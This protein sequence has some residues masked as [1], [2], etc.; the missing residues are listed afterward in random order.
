MPQ[1]DT[2]TL[3]VCTCHIAKNHGPHFFLNQ[4]RLRQQHQFAYLFVY[5]M[6]SRPAADATRAI[7]DPMAS[8]PSSLSACLQ[9]FALPLVDGV[10]A[11]ADYGLHQCERV[12]VFVIV[13]VCV[14]M[15]LCECFYAMLI[16]FNSYL[17]SNVK[18]HGKQEQKR[19]HWKLLP[20]SVRWPPRALPAIRNVDALWFCGTFE[21][22]TVA[23]WIIPASDWKPTFQPVYN[24]LTA[25][26]R[27]GGLV[28]LISLQIVYKCISWSSI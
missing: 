1:T 13:S 26:L 17:M 10:S 28:C 3:F 23:T 16:Y 11:V 20:T 22:T 6:Q 2:H 12:Y 8:P 5:C 18:A 14:W 27:F 25:S 24:S 15:W 9:L 19:K 4:Q 7:C 21:T